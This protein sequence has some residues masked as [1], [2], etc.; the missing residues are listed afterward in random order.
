MTY[1]YNPKTN[2]KRILFY[3]FCIV[4]ILA[5]IST[6]FFMQKLSALLCCAACFYLS[7]Y[8]IK[9]IRGFMSSKIVTYMEGFTVYTSPNEKL[10]FDWNKITHAGHITGGKNNGH[11]FAYMESEDKI[12][13]LPPIFVDFNSFV[14][15]LKE[16]SPWQ[17]Y[18]LSDD[19]TISSYLK[20]Q[21]VVQ[22]EKKEDN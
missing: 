10:E 20:K 21:L 13:V 19:E 5:G 11:I 17:E 22:D 16:Q 15:E 2:K 18:T 8:T 12:I 4:C 9:T 7:W 1:K 6:F 3:I 14:T